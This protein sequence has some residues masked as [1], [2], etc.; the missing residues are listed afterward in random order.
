M[1]D[2]DVDVVVVRAG[3]AG[4]SAARTLAAAGRTVIVLEARDRVARYFG[5]AAADAFE[6]KEQDWAG[7]ESSDIWNGYMDGAVRSGRRAA[8]EILAARSS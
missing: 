3:P 1:N 5:P 4:L 2:V 8:G 7:A 6:V